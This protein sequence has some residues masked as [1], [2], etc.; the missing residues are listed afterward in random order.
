MSLN[1]T[2]LE[3]FD[4]VTIFKNKSRLTVVHGGDDTRRREMIHHWCK[5]IKSSDVAASSQTRIESRIY[6]VSRPPDESKIVEWVNSRNVHDTQLLT[7]GGNITVVVPKKVNPFIIMIENV[8]CDSFDKFQTLKLILE[9]RE[10]ANLFVFVSGTYLDDL[11]RKL[12]RLDADIVVSLYSRIESVRSMLRNERYAGATIKGD[13][14]GHTVQLMSRQH[15]DEMYN[16]AT[17][18]HR[19]H[20]GGRA[21]VTT[22]TAAAATDSPYDAVGYSF[23]Y[24]MM[25]KPPSGNLTTTLPSSSPPEDWERISIDNDDDDE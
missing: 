4:P 14:D 3:D 8:D 17:S 15:F 25:K 1:Y 18:D 24:R 10:S 7:V 2:L 19:L 9:Q 22:T 13:A 23:V 11:P 21:L 6:N 20:S 5:M 16:S 12:C